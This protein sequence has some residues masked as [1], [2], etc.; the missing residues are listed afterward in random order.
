MH[1]QQ[2]QADRQHRQHTQQRQQGT[3]MTAAM[4]ATQ[5][6]I[7]RLATN[8]DTLPADGTSVSACRPTSGASSDDTVATANDSTNIIVAMTTTCASERSRHSSPAAFEIIVLPAA[9]RVVAAMAPPGRTTGYL[10]AADAAALDRDLMS[11]HAFSL[12]QLMELAGLSVASVVRDACPAASRPIVVCGP[13]NNGGDGLVAARHLAQFGLAPTVVY[14]TDQPKQ[15]IYSRL[16]TQ[17]NDCRIPVLPDLPADL[18]GFDVIVDAIF[19]FSFHGDLRAPFDTIVE[20]MNAS[21]LPCVAVDVPSGWH[22]EQGNVS[23]NGVQAS[24]LGDS[25][26]RR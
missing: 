4:I 20:R 21:G 13:G 3:T 17:C 15:P 12:D 8:D 25:C 14:P 11:V 1:G 23:G 22:V 10:G 7:G 24:V 19:G 2:Q 9:G 6:Q 26:R 18:S 5:A 16:L